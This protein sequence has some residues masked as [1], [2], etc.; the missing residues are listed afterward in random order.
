MNTFNLALIKRNTKCFRHNKDNTAAINKLFALFL[1]R[2]RKITSQFRLSLL[3]KLVVEQMPVNA[4][5]LLSLQSMF[6]FSDLRCLTIC[7]AFFFFSLG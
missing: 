3:F 2:K 7:V 4:E 1:W 6:V 5:Y